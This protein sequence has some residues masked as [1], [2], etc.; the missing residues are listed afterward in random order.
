MNSKKFEYLNKDIPFLKKDAALRFTFALIYFAIFTWQFASLVAKNIRKI[1]ITTPMIISTIFVM[2]MSLLFMGL[3][4]MYCFKSMKILD[5]IKKDG[6]CVS[7]VEILFN[8]SKKGFMKLYSF[9]TEVLAIVCSIVVICS[10]IY[11]ALD[12]VYFASISYYMPVLAVLCCCGFYSAYHINSE[13]D[14]VK[15]VQM[16]NSIY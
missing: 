1:T 16:F 4:L 9:I 8:T 6:R 13:I 10:I 15:N 3:S 2:L 14:I 5:V 7:S 11:I 12:A